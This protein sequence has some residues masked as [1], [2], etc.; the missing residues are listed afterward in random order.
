MMNR[1][2]VT[3][4]F[5]GRLSGANQELSMEIEAIN[6]QEAITTATIE[7]LRDPK[8]GQ[9]IYVKGATVNEVKA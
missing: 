1:Y 4:R 2:H 7:A 3:I 9:S 8:H 6:V 5:N